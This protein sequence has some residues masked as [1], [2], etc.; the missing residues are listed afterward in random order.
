MMYTKKMLRI[1][2]ETIVDGVIKRFEDNSPV[3]KS[4]QDMLVTLKRLV[5]FGVSYFLFLCYLQ[6]FEVL[7]VVFVGIVSL[8]VSLY[9]IRKSVRSHIFKFKKYRRESSI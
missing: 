6:R 7:A 4:L 8:A 5:V 1:K 3:A 9:L 2:E